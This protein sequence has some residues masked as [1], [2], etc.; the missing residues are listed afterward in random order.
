[1]LNLALS[2]A[3]ASSYVAAIY[4][5][6]PP[7][8]GGKDRNEPHVIRYRFRRITVLCIVLVLALPWIVQDEKYS[9]MDIIRQLGLCP[10]LSHSMNVWTDIINIVY[11]FVL[12][13]VLFVGP[14]FLY[15]VQPHELQDDFINNFTTIHGIRDHI[16]APITE[17]LIYRGVI[18]AITQA[19]YTPY[20]FGVA[21]IHHAYHLYKYKGIQLSMVLFNSAFQ[22][23]YTSLFGILAN[24][25]YIK[26]NYNLWCP[27]VVHM[28]CNLMGFPSLVPEDGEWQT[29]YYILLVVG[30]GG[31][32]FL[33]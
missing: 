21:H 27:I 30:L 17:E 13:I 24:H 5:H 2:L 10:G 6:Q 15:L 8:V 16:F 9:Y 22:F 33:L 28:M 11:S 23:V 7:Q 18:L 4:F 19:W 20:L 1:M 12:I 32:F 25:I 26:Y 14:I 31:F 3:V 29:V